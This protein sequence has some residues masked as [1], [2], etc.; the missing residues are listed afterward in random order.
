MEPNDYYTSGEQF[1]PEAA[2]GEYFTDLEDV[3]LDEEGEHIT[4][5]QQRLV[6]QGYLASV[7]GRFDDDTRQALIGFG[8]ANGE[9]IGTYIDLVASV[10]QQ[11]GPLQSV[12]WQQRLAPRY[13]ATRRLRAD[14]SD[15]SQPGNQVWSGQARSQTYYPDQQTAGDDY[16]VTVD[17]GRVTIPGETDADGNPIYMD[18]TDI[19][20]R[21]GFAGSQPERMIYT[22]DDQGELRMADPAAEMQSR[23]GMRFHHSSLV[24][25]ED[26]ASAGEMKI[27][28]GQVEAV[29]D[30]SGHYRPD[31]AMTAQVDER[32]REGGVDTSRVTYELG[33]FRA[34]AELPTD[35]AALLD[36]VM[37]KCRAIG[38]QRGRVKWQPEV[39]DRLPEDTKVAEIQATVDELYPPFAAMDDPTLKAQA[40]QFLDAQQDT[41]I[42]GT[43]LGSY[44]RDSTLA[45]LR[46]R[47]WKE[48][49]EKAKAKWKPSVWQRL[50]PPIKESEIQSFYDQVYPTF[51]AMDDR[52]LMAEARKIIEG[53]HQGLRTL[54]QDIPFA[55]GWREDPLGR[56]QWRWY[57]GSQWTATVSDD[58]VAG[59]DAEGAALLE[60]VA[61]STGQNAARSGESEG[62]E[63][64]GEPIYIEDPQAN[65]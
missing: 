2:Q 47:C 58:D 21:A 17:A 32:L 54:M 29:S 40:R 45:D 15:E 57:D 51:E 39:W 23:P 22:M 28:E 10:Q 24:A 38:D 26:V 3:Q 65:R 55:M 49:E 41:R 20:T 7:S 43:E 30:K 35:R 9:S 62:S 53:R 61:T 18:T 46:S 34:P 1:M 5:V 50:A 27:R 36:L 13:G 60:G 48:A 59:E 6:D 31:F 63:A 25:G 44:D 19:T 11:T 12:A 52:A 4:E 16:G 33:N 56:H 42:T 14:F 8:Q 37:Q 64:Q